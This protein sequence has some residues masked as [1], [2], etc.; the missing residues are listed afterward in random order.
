MHMQKR[1]SFLNYRHTLKSYEPISIDK[2]L[3]FP[4]IPKGSSD[5]KLPCMT[6]KKLQDQVRVI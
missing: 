6:A 5:I 2:S 1:Q 3:L 4:N